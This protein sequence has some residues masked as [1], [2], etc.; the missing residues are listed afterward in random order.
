MR[1]LYGAIFFLISLNVSGQT[2]THVNSIGNFKNAAAFSINPAANIYVSDIATNEISKYDTLGNELQNIGGY[3]WTAETFD[4]PVDIFATTLNVYVTDKNNDRIQIFDK[5]LNFLSEFTT[6]NFE[7]EEYIFSYPVSCA[8]SPQGDLFILDSD[9]SRVLKYDL[10]GNFLIEIGNFDWGKFALNEPY[11][12]A[13]SADNKLF[14]SDENKILAFDQYGTGL[15]QLQTNMN[16]VN[17]NI[18]FNMLSY[19]NDS[20]IKIMNLTDPQKNRME[21][22][23]DILELDADIIEAAMFKN[24]LYVLTENKIHIYSFR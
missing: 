21:I 18:T 3:G 6:K 2:F 24:K 20:T 10:N 9:N 11:R 23:T 22:T 17:I 8:T 14:V 4:E 12:L 19:N 16:R 7:N 5:D 15:L 13:I 1:L